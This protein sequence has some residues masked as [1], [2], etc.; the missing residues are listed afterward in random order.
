ML[1]LELI[2]KG[3][4]QRV[5]YRRSIYTY[6]TESHPE[7]V[8][9][10]QNQPDGSVMIK[11]YGGLEAL[12][13]IRSYAHDGVSGATVRESSEN[14]IPVDIESIEFNDFSILSE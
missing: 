6:V 14:I 5:G 1:E 8:G 13:K 10:V 7:V 3:Q 11:I 4:V 12:K 2:L 9:F